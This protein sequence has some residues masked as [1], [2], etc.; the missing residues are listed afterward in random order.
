M[1]TARVS[2]SEAREVVENALL[3]AGITADAAAVQATWLIE[4]ELRG[5]PS[6]GIQRLP[7]LVGRARGGVI[8]G[9][10][11]P[12]VEW[13]T[14]AVG[15]LDGRRAVGPLAGC[16][17]VD[18]ACERASLTGL[19]LVAISNANH[20]GL[21]A[22]YVERAVERGQIA[23]V[24]TTSEA[25]VHPWGAAE[26]MVGTNPIAVGVPADPSPFILDMATGASSRGKILSHAAR[27]LPL[28]PGWAV[29]AQGVPTTDAEAAAAIS[30]FGGP[31]GYA[32]GLAFELLVGVIA[33]AAFG[34]DVT[35]TLDVETVCNKGDLVICV[36]PRRLG[37]H[38]PLARAS[39]YLEALRRLEPAP[40]HDGVA[41][42]GDRARARRAHAVSDGIEVPETVWREAMRLSELREVAT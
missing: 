28:E 22:P 6:H 39:A 23:M 15:V 41:I 27:G 11:Q 1:T 10:A 20:L 32:L 42:P 21:L 2:R 18:A 37:V 36:D 5:H 25:L 13:P 3:A 30:P 38:E 17:A 33:R 34:R 4:A 7:V 26:P 40:G 31:K 29:D 24:L 12:V 35:G 16:M 9:S 8:D 19:A 14:V